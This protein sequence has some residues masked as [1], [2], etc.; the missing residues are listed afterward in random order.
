[1]SCSSCNEC[2]HMK[3]NTLEKLWRCLD[4][5]RPQIHLDADLIRRARIPIDRMLAI[6]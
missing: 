6:G 1:G 2:P 5:M 4:T 3:R